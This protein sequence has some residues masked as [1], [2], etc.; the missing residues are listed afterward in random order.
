LDIS[1]FSAFIAS[2]VDPP[3]ALFWMDF[4]MNEKTAF[5]KRWKGRSNGS[6]PRDAKSPSNASQ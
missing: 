4:R 5:R 1:R 6:S 3:R 2:S